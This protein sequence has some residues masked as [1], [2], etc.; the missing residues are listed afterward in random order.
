MA[1]IT[2]RFT[3]KGREWLAKVLGAKAREMAP[4]NLGVLYFRIGEGGFRVL[5]SFVKVPISPAERVGMN[6]LVAGKGIG[7]NLIIDPDLPPPRTINVLPTEV[8]DVDASLYFVEKVLTAGNIVVTQTGGV[9]KAEVTCTLLLTEAN[10][11][12]NSQGGVN[13]HF[14][15]IGLF[16]SVLEGINN[17]HY[18]LAYGTFPEEIKTNAVQLINKVNLEV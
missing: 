8:P 1:G 4:L 9:W 18:M 15:E 3:D 13:P 14:F 12:F 10:K 16:A 17:I 2:A 11:T 7:G 6:G 5:P